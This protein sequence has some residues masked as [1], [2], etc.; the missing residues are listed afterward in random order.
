MRQ[1][2]GR[3]RMEA[4]FECRPE[5][6]A[7]A[8]EF[9][10]TALA[11]WDLDDEDRV[12]ALLTSEIVTNAVLHAR[13]AC[14]LAIEFQAPEVTVEVWDHSRELPAVQSPSTESVKGRGLLLVEALA[15]RWGTRLNDEGKS[16]W[17]ALNCLQPKMASA[18]L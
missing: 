4:E 3:L 7:A 18:A 5:A 8:R 16:V 14:R 1:T 10:E 15:A 11:V 9:I 17:F 12:A 2:G 6:V 13:S